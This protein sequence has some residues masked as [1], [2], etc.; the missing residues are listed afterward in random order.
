MDGEQNTIFFPFEF[1]HSGT[2]LLV[3]ELPRRTAAGC[4]ADPSTHPLS[5]LYPTA[6]STF[7]LRSMCWHSETDVRGT[8]GGLRDHS[9]HVYSTLVGNSGHKSARTD[10]TIQHHD[11]RMR[12]DSMRTQGH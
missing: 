2:K 9:S 1:C 6:R 3:Q 4:C 7:G 12:T 10:T 8:L 5:H 11:Y